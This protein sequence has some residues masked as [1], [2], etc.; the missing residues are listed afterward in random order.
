MLK[1]WFNEAVFRIGLLLLVMLLSF[2][3]A[4][5]GKEY[6]ASNGDWI[7]ASIGL[8]LGAV[9]ATLVMVRRS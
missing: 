1:V 6:D 2:G 7:G 8:G 3:G 5:V 9:L 4:A